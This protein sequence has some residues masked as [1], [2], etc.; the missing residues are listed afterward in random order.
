[1]YLADEYHELFQLQLRRNE[2]AAMRLKAMRAKDRFAK[3]RK[4]CVDVFVKLVLKL[5]DNL[6]AL[7]Q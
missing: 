6:H 1:M 7:I 2:L 4:I 3:M 5:L